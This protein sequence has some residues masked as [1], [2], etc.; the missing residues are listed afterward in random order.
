[1]PSEINQ[2]EKDKCSM[3]SSICGIG[4]VQQT[5]EHNKKR[6]GLTDIEN[7]SVVTSRERE[8]GGA[9]QEEGIRRYKLLGI[10]QATSTVQGIK[11]MFY[12]T[13]F[14]NCESL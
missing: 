12:N 5:S 6:S 3:L 8:W 1:M 9:I 14:K 13:G 10:K 2:T 11:P 4:K 7:K